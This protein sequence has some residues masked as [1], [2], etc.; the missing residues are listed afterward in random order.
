[1][2]PQPRTAARCDDVVTTTK[3]AKTPT[4][5]PAAAATAARRRLPPLPSRLPL[6]A[7]ELQSYGACRAGACLT[8]VLRGSHR[9]ALVPGVLND[10][11][12][13]WPS[14]GR[15]VARKAA[16]HHGHAKV[17]RV[18]LEYPVLVADPPDEVC[19]ASFMH[20]QQLV[21]LTQH[22]WVVARK[23]GN[24]ECPVA[25]PSLLVGSVVRQG[26]S[27]SRRLQRCRLNGCPRRCRQL[28]EG[29]AV[30]CL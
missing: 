27:R 21:D 23:M 30:L 13:E 3:S 14:R 22:R 29:L 12:E 24:E 8:G 20:V 9:S 17:V 2:Q 19:F 26:T 4:K 28:C 11:S 1:M 18:I 6:P 7:G 16:A 5:E 25:P 10:V 15:H